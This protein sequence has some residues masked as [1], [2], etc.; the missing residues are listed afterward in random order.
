MTL[1]K[2]INPTYTE[3]EIKMFANRRFNPDGTWKRRHYM[4]ITNLWKWNHP[5]HTKSCGIT[6]P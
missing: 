5:P 1:L 6:W 3:D 4:G 2:M